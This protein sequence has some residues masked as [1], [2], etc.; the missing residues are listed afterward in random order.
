M[1]VGGEHHF[2]DAIARDGSAIFAVWHENLTL[3]IAKFRGSGY[4]TLTSYSFDGQLAAELGDQVGLHALRGSSSRGGHEALLQLKK[5]VELKI[6]VGITVDG[7]RGPRRVAKPGVAVLSVFTGLPVMPI[8]FTAT[9]AWHLKS[10][11][12]T[13]LPKPFAQICVEF[14]P[15]LPPPENGD[16]ELHRQAI[17]TALNTL[18][19]NLEAKTGVADT[20][21][22]PRS[23]P[24]EGG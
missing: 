11:D 10:W 2:R 15:P 5:A 21:E 18:Q 4:H 13:I 8:A 23:S 17:E 20:S 22:H 24:F 14:G 12:R 9:R 1:N 16:V 7:P 6:T 3:A 19:T